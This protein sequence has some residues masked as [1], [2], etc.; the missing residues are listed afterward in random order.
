VKTWDF[1]TWGECEEFRLAETGF[2]EV[3][4]LFKGN[5]EGFEENPR[6]HGPRRITFVSDEEC[7]CHFCC[8]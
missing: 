8:E 4:L 3:E 2:E 6:S 1:S 5:V 7:I